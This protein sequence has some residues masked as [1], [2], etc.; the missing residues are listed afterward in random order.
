MDYLFQQ[1]PT[2]GYPTA[3]FLIVAVI[4]MSLIIIRPYWAFLF[5]VGCFAARNVNAA[6]FTRLDV[7][8]EY[9]NLNDLLLWIV[10]IAMIVNTVKKK[11]KILLPKIIVAL[12]LVLAIGTLQSLF[13]Y[14]IEPFVLRS[15]WAVAIFP[16]LFIV[17]VNMVNSPIQ[18][19][20]FYWALFA[21]ALLA[22][23]QHMFFIGATYAGGRIEGAEL[24]TIAYMFS[25][26]Y[27]IIAVALFSKF[28]GKGS[29]NRF[30]Y[31]I[32]LG[33]IIFS[34]LMNQTR[35]LYVIFIL[36]MIIM[37]FL[38]M[39]HIEIGKNIVKIFTITTI[40]LLIA[41][42]IFTNIGFREMFSQRFEFLQEEDV[43]ESSYLTR[44]VGMNTELDIWLNS[45]IILGTGTSYPPD[46]VQAYKNVDPKMRMDMYGA[47]DHVAFSSYLAHFGILGA[48]LYLFLLPFLTLRAAYGLARNH[49]N[50]YLG[51]V[52]LLA[53][54][55]AVFYMINPFGSM[56]YT[57]SVTSQVPALIFGALW[58]V[59][60]NEKKTN[61]I[62]IKNDTR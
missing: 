26:G 61:I 39:R 31:Y 14:G 56:L 35:Q 62:R 17:S 25:G 53:M 24:R 55:A 46:I 29:A 21:G 32:G 11:R 16:I 45:T 41:G 12:I 3:V 4:G 13:K 60:I 47:L 51:K 10:L 9:L 27:F 40:S 18:S 23:L 15:I 37:F 57:A 59:Y 54:T 34:L 42:I 5:S 48:I 58:G 38:F 22:A 33:L 19:R 8:G 44:W 30:F 49:M 36:L 2:D 20:R 6:V 43:R 52:A 7:T 28:E 50:D 1:V